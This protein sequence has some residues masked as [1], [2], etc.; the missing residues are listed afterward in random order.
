MTIS[1]I[2][3]A[4][5]KHVHEAASFWG[6]KRKEGLPVQEASFSCGKGRLKCAYVEEEGKFRLI[7]IGASAN[8]RGHLVRTSESFKEDSWCYEIAPGEFFWWD[9]FGPQKIYDSLVIF[10]AAYSAVVEKGGGYEMMR[11]ILGKQSGHCSICGAFLSDELSTQRGIGPECWKK[12]GVKG[13]L[14]TVQKKKLDESRKK[15]R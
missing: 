2:S 12:I 6:G 5:D 13:M 11:Q 4:C 14:R 3:K 15:K 9:R 1:E 7:Y 8:V 10:A